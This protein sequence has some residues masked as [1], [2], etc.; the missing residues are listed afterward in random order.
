MP[1]RLHETGPDPEVLEALRGLLVAAER[2]ELT[3]FAFV[4]RTRDGYQTK[5]AGQWDST[6]ETIG[7]LEFFRVSL[8]AAF[9]EAD[10]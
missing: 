10:K 5:S 3:A 2:G 6:L 1:L 9:L 7:A 8:L 4:A